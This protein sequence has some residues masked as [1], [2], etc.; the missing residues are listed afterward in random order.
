MPNRFYYSVFTCIV[1]FCCTIVNAF[2]VGFVQNIGQFHP[3]VVFQGKFSGTYVFAEN[4]GITFK[5]KDEKHYAD[6]MHCYHQHKLNTC[7]DTINGHVL[8]LEWQGNNLVTPTGLGKQTTYINY[9]L[10]NNP[11]KWKSKVP[12][13]D[14]IVYENIYDGIKGEFYYSQ[15]KTK[16]DYIVMPGADV[17]L[18]KWRYQGANNIKIKRGHLY[19]GTSIGDFIEQAPYAYQIKEGKRITIDCDFVLDESVI[20]FKIGQYDTTLQLVIDPILIF[21]TYSGSEGDNFGFTATFDSHGSLYA[22]GIV[23]NIQGDYPV[24]FGAFQMVYGGRGAAQAPIFLPSDIAISKYDSTGENLLYATYLGGDNNEHPHSLVVDEYDNLIVFGTTKSKNFPVDSLGFDTTHNGQFDMVLVKLSKDGSELLASTFLGG[25]QDDAINNGNLRFNYADDFRGDVYVD[26][27]GFV[28]VAACTRSA[29]FVFPTGSYQP[30]KSGGLDAVLMSFYPDFKKIRW[31]T[32]IGGSGED[33][34]Y[35]VKVVKGKVFVSG[36]TTNNT[37]NTSANGYQPAFAGGQADGF[38]A[39]FDTAKGTLEKFTFFG[40]PAYDQ[41]YFLD[42]DKEDNIYFT[43]QT[44]GYLQRTVGTY[45]KDSAGQFV[46]KINFDLD[47]LNFQTTFGNR[48]LNP[49]LSPG[50]FMVDNCDNIYFSG[51]GSDIDVNPGTTRNLPVTADAL[52]KTTDNNDFYLIV[53]SREA[54][55]L[56]YATYFGGS[57]SDDHVDGGTSRFDKRGIVYQSVCSSCPNIP[58]NTLNDFPTT[59]SSAFPINVSY[60]CSNAAFKIDFQISYNV[61]ADFE[62]SPISGCSPLNVKMNNKSLGKSFIWDFGDGNKDTA[63]NPQFIFRGQ[64]EKP[65]KLYVIDSLSCNILDTMIKSI[66]LTSGAEALFDYDFKPCLSEVSFTSQTQGASSLLWDFGDGNSTTEPNPTHRYAAP[67]TYTV[68]LI[69]FHT[70]GCS[71]TLDLPF[72][73]TGIASGELRLFNVFTPNDDDLNP[74]FEPLGLVTG[75]DTGSMVIFNRWG[76]KVFDG[77]LPGSCWNG[78]NQYNNQ[79]V[80]DG[81]YFYIIDIERSGIRGKKISGVVHLISH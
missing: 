63:Y 13:F 3:N 78:T 65:I 50:A 71:D 40:T 32:F 26:S 23:D 57:Q 61:K 14:K 76:D 53:L 58:G 7:I 54:K 64:G 12:I 10:G 48:A 79:K 44:K 66:T 2:A 72:E 68:K 69:T 74:C 62:P 42:F 39:R 5:M 67:G 17:S 29:D 19:V 56:Y 70:S 75:C 73:I 22:G 37:I 51:W 25:N 24:T 36:G 20:G 81:V 52:Q 80:P 9:F 1:I 34:A 49:E 31:G 27:A 18:I 35:S 33:A 47:S 38:I 60:R 21:S 8:K 55:K 15:G 43:G 28:F 6:F 11:E 59:T 4:D 30:I 41:I 45:G 77:P 46:G 16:Y